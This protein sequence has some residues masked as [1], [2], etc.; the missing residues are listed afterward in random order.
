ML[1]FLEGKKEP[2]DTSNLQI[3]GGG[4]EG[5]LYKLDDFV[6]KISKSDLSNM[7]EEKLKDLRDSIPNDEKIRIVPPI[8]IASKS[9][10][11]KNLKLN[12]AF[13]YTER[14]IK[15]NPSFIFSFDKDH[16]FDEMHLLRKQVHCYMS[17]NSIGLM[18]TNPNNILVSSD[19]NG[20]YLIDHD[21][22]VTVSSQYFERSRI[23][24]GDYF[25]HNDQKLQLI[26]YKTLLLQLL[27][28]NG[29]DGTNVGD[30]VLLF[31]E[32]EGQ[33]KDI[34][35][36]YIEKVLSQYSTLSEYT[37]DTVKRIKNM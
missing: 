29:I 12:P 11:I 28:Y 9:N 32:N 8:S 17:K 34:T 23:T 14:F 25:C 27:R 24:Y 37:E 33:R 16:F 35:Y 1:V 26:V 6:L 20:I 3:I 5:T 30:R 4:T 10:Q 18:D 7:T 15:E 36:K 13:G 19:N 31:V 22:D 21:R 2:I